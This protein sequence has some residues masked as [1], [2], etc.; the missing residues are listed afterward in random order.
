LGSEY[1]LT[2]NVSVKSEIMYFDMGSDSYNIAGVPTDIRRN[3]FISTLGLH[4]R[5][6]G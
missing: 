2:Q 3:G 5:F 4:F 6:G 1:G